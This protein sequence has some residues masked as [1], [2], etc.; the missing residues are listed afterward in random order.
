MGRG[1]PNRVRGHGRGQTR[2]L[3]Q[4]RSRGRRGRAIGGIRNFDNSSLYVP[5]GHTPDIPEFS[6]ISG[7]K[8]LPDG[9]RPL[10]FFRLFL[11]DEFLDYL[12]SETNKYADILHA[13][14]HAHYLKSR[15]QLG[16]L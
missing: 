5:D 1:Q 3:G 10:D 12:V 9:E 4:V 7:L 2:G 14:F 13:T 16:Y 6:A 11:T 8:V 15:L